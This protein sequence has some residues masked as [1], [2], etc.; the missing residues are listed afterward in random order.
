[1]F[2]GVRIE[3]SQHVIDPSLPRGTET[4][5]IRPAD[6]RGARAER[7]CLDDIGTSTDAPVVQNDRRADA[8]LP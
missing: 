8:E 1:V 3:E 5:E 6:H 7:H 2:A 4:I